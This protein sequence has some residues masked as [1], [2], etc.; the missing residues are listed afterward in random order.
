MAGRFSAK[1]NMRGLAKAGWGVACGLWLA[2]PAPADLTENFDA[3]TGV[4]AGWTDGGTVNDNVSGHYQSAPNCRAMGAGD[5]LQTPAVDYPTNLS[6]FVDASSNGNNKT[7]TVDYALS[8]TNWIALGTFVSSTAG[9]TKNF[10][11]NASPNLAAS[12]GVR[13]RFN[14]TFST[15]YLD[16]VIVRTAAAAASNSPPTL[17]LV[18][19]QTNWAVEVG[20]TVAVAVVATESDGDEIVLTG[21]DVPADAVFAP[22]PATGLAPLTNMFT[23]VTS[24]AGV[25]DI[26]FQA[27]DKDGTNEVVLNVTVSEPDPNL[28]LAEDFDDSGSLPDGWTDGGTV[29]D[30]GHFQSAPNCRALGSGDTVTTPAVDFPTNLSFYVDAST[31]GNGQM[32]FAY[33]RIGTN[34]WSELGTFPAPAAGTNLSFS[35]LEVANVAVSEDVQFLFYSPFN[36]W[37]LDD[38]LV[39][40]HS[41]IDQPPALVPVGPQTVALSNTLAVAVVATDY[42]QD[43]ITLYASNLP[44]GAVF[45]VAT[46]AGG[47]TNVLTYAPTD[48]EVGLVYTSTVYAADVN[49]IAEENFTIS[50]FDRLVRFAAATTTVWEA[51]GTVELAVVLSRPGDATVEVFTAGTATTGPDG[52]V[53]LAAST[54]TFAADGSP[55]QWLEL[56]IAEDVNWE[57]V[58]TLQLGLTNAVGAEVGNPRQSTVEIRDD[59]AAYFNAFDENPGWSTQG[60]WAFGRPLGGGYYD[61]TAG[62]TGTNVYG[63]NLAGNYANNISTPYYLTTPAIDCS[64]FLNVRLE[65]SRLLIVQGAPYDHASIQASRDRQ[66]WTTIWTNGTSYV[67]DWEWTWVTYDI[68]AIADGAPAVYLRWSLGPTDGS[69]AY[70]GWNIDDVT[71]AGDYVTNALF[72]FSE[73]GY[74]VRETAAEANV[75]IERY[76]RTNDAAEIQFVAGNGTALDGADFDALAETVVFAP[77]ESNRTVSIALWDD[78]EI[79]GNETIDL[80]LVP[81]ATGATGTPAV[82]TLVVQDDETPG[83]SLPFFDGFEA[84]AWSNG[85]TSTSSGNG[86]IQ[87]GPGAV[88]PFEGAGHVLLD[89]TNYAYGLNELVLT[90]N[91]AGQTNVMFGYQENNFDYWNEAMPDSFVGSTNADGVAISGDGIH[92]FKLGAPSA[93]TGSYTNRSFDLSA[94]AASR[95][96]ALDANF[97]IKFQQYDYYSLPTFGRCFDNVQICDTTQVA[98]VRLGIQESENPVAPG[99][100][101]T[102]ALLITNA[103]PLAVAAVVVSN[104]LPTG[105]TFVSAESSQGECAQEAD[106]VVAQL[107]ALAGGGTAT[108][109][110]VVVPDGVGVL[111][112]RGWVAHEQFDPVRTNNAAVATTVVDEPGGVLQLDRAE[113]ERFER[114]G[115]LAVTVVRSDHVYGEIT[116]AFATVAG[117]ALAGEDYVAT[118]GT[119]TLASGQTSAVIPVSILDDDVEEATETFALTL[120]EPGGGAMLGAC[121]STVVA[122]VDDDGRAAFPFLETFESGALS[123]FWRTY[124][125]TGG[126]VAVT[127]NY[128]P[129]GGSCHL[130]MDAT[131]S[132]GANDLNELVLTANLAGQQG[133][134][135][136]F[137]HKQFSDEDHLMSATFA[138]HQNVD[139]VA[140][141]MDGTN[142]VKVQGLTAAEGSSNT[143][144]YFEVALDP[145]AAANGLAYT[146]TFKIKF[147][148]YDNFPIST[149]GFVFDDIALFARHGELHFGQAEFEAAETGGVVVVSVDRANGSYGEVTVP[150]VVADGTATAGADYVATTGTLTFANGV[151]T[152][153]FAVAVLDDADDEPAETV[154]LT[155]GAPTGGA[156][157]ATPSNAVLTLLD[158]DGPGELAFSTNACDVVES[159][160]TATIVVW[161]R[162]G[163]E[164][165]VAIDVAAT[166]GTATGGLDYLSATNTLTFAAGVTQ[167]EFAVAILDDAEREDTETVALA[168]ANPVGGASLGSP[169]TALLRIVDDED[170]N[171]DYYLPAYGKTGPELRQALHDIIRGHVAFSYD[172]LWT[173]LQQTDECPTNSA[174]VQL[175]YLQIGRDKNNSGGYSGQWNREHVW[176]QSHGFPDALSTAVPPSVDAHHVKPSDVEVNSLRGEKD[177][178][179][180]GTHVAGAP[181]SCLTTS[182]TFAPPDESK[183]DVARMLFYMDVRYSG[184]V[185]GEPDLQLVDA[186]DTSGTQLGRLSTLIRWHFLD[187]PDDFERH[188]NDLIYA[189]WQ[190]NRNPFIDHPEWVLKIWDYNV[191]IATVAGAHGGISPANPQVPYHADQE[192][193]IAPEPHYHVADVRTNGVSLGAA[194]GT[195]AYSFVWSQIVTNGTVAADFAENL[196]AG[197]GVPETWLAAHDV[198]NEFDAAELD[199]PDGD[200]AATWQEYF[201]GTHP[202]DPD[203]V[204]RLDSIALALDG[205]AA[206][207]YVLSWPAATGR[208]YDV[209]YLADPVGDAWQPLEGLTNLVSETGTLSVT[210][211]FHDGSLRL[212][213]LQVRLP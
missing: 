72:R 175:V 42:D 86:R 10:P 101:L 103:G 137:W 185:D 189:N 45:D 112:N 80:R 144:G 38:V 11:L 31:A 109:S 126:H 176:P 130:A 102:Y 92:W 195:S 49:G 120:A 87:V 51:D 3:S 22:N 162:G 208:V 79:E 8:G 119:L 78:A 127:T 65:F 110:V 200:G 182:S 163:A 68:S 66:N 19:S 164:G 55:T 140:M 5:T 124:S 143:Y 160:G 58:E 74:S 166:D 37:Y 93:R 135:L 28:L 12:P 94:A 187:P 70:C 145:I 104:Q 169:A 61:P 62:S 138:G 205:D 153:A 113:N 129:H 97:Q 197:H 46:N 56:A 180:G 13:F 16:D 71:L 1:D 194:Y 88:A 15:W 18:P 107:G 131:N 188:R 117:T 25:Y 21:I 9:G 212:L 133:V 99:S 161:R 100:N 122:I 48:A 90:V 34:E 151:S 73:A 128:G 211:A 152:G 24:T 47:I 26:A 134:T 181:A 2:L 142:W 158:D 14:S 39:R 147:Q 156:V 40:G 196:T 111:T 50:V 186:V 150:Y 202:G 172:T 32:A 170:P 83:V 190:G 67:V 207:G 154:F 44:P 114:S 82:A 192:F 106:C 4:P 76:G 213:R 125:S 209:E 105:A 84:G 59:D 179:D 53:Q 203:S 116:V 52:D 7:G 27:A 81:T 108:V 77:G 210:N 121:T 85:W 165:E 184:D 146:S 91:L 193:V 149:D 174:Q 29:N 141:S 148:Q 177:F 198:T 96:L 43:E 132:T 123:N 41:L 89:A 35:L 54:V 155:L 191:A 6:F 36:T 204:L 64:Q 33:Y 173:V 69:G 75:T 139:G 183:G 157:L 199:D 201:M 57:A 171:Y 167:Q 95:G 115:T 60:Q 136:A 178:D 17:F 23:W 30:S 168:L 159:N 63:Y 98:D 118:N 20:A 206:V